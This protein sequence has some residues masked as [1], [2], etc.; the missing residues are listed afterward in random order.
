MGRIYDPTAPSLEG[1]QN[2]LQTLTNVSFHSPACEVGK[3]FHGATKNQGELESVCATITADPVGF[4]AAKLGGGKLVKSC[5]LN[6]FGVVC[7][8]RYLSLSW[9]PGCYFSAC[10]VLLLAFCR[11]KI[12]ICLLVSKHLHID[13][14]IFFFNSLLFL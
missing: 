13:L 7:R 1:F 10:S 14:F 6:L 8:C 11:A 4:R 3:Y 5:N 12:R 2:H 9:E